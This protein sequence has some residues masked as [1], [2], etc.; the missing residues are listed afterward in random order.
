MERTL[1]SRRIPDEDV[2]LLRGMKRLIAGCSN[3]KS[4]A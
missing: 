2:R 3:Y 1:A 4:C